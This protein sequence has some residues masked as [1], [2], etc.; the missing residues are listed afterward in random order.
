MAR[1]PKSRLTTPDPDGPHGQMPM[2]KAR[3]APNKDS[4]LGVG[5]GATYGKGKMS[6]RKGC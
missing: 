3:K 2:G 5:A 6:S 1:M 4:K